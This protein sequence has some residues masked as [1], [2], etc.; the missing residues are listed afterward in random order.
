MA[1][2]G[3]RVE[4]SAVNFNLIRVSFNFNQEFFVISSTSL[5]DIR[6]IYII[7]FNI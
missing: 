4:K 2:G 7:F 5:L 1:D 6:K 3:I